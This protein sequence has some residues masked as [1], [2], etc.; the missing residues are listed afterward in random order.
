MDIV[1]GTG[2]AAAHPQENPGIVPGM[3]RGEVY[4]LHAENLAPYG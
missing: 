4:D 3:D 1:T 2:K